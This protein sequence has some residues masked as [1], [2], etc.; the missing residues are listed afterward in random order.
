M[1]Y[2]PNFRDD[3]VAGAK[4]IALYLFGEAT[5]ENVRAA[6]YRATCRRFETF[7]IGGALC[8]RKADLDAYLQRSRAVS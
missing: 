5:P 4:E 6:Y 3:I 1:T 2:R 8:A 7:R